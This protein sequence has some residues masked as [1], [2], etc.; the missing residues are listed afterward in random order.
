MSI[1]DVKKDFGRSEQNVSFQ[2]VASPNVVFK[3]VASPNIAFQNIPSPNVAFQNM[4]S[5]NV[6]SQNVVSQNIFK[7][8][9]QEDNDKIQLTIEKD[10]SLEKMRQ[11]K[12]D[13]SLPIQTIQLENRFHK[14]VC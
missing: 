5:P 3:N 13:L 6:V 2:N 11:L 12:Q 14:F 1:S 9:V 8:D 4:A 10:K 7:I